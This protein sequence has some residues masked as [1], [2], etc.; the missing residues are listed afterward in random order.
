[1]LAT[2]IQVLVITSF[3][4]YVTY[5]EIMFTV[6]LVKIIKATFNKEYAAKQPVL[7]KE[8]YTINC[9]L[10]LTLLWLPIKTINS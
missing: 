6:L 7:W 2:F 4:V 5:S 8:Y 10:Y 1:M 3:V 9:I